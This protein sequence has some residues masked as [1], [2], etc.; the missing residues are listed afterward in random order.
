M[1]TVQ[2]GVTANGFVR[3]P[4]DVIIKSLNN[5]FRASF[6][7]TFDVSPESPDGQVIGI[8]ADEISACWTQAEH[9][10][11]AYRPGATIGIGLD[12]IC[13]L[14]RVVRYKD[15]PSSA[16]V[17]LGGSSG[18]VIP[19]GSIV[20]DDSG[21]E[22]VTTEDASL[23]GQVT[24]N[25]TTLGEIYIAANTITKIIT[26]VD[27]WKTV[28]NP[29]IGQTGIEF[30][31]DPA[32]RVRREKTTAISGIATVESIYARL[33]SLDLEYIRIRDNDTHAPIGSQPPGTLYVVVDGGNPNEIARRIYEGKTGGVPTHGE[34]SVEVKDSK[35]NPHTIKF[36]RTTPQEIY[37]TATFKR[38]AGSNLGSNDAIEDLQKAAANYINSLQ[39]GES[40]VWSYLFRPLTAAVPNIE[41]NSLFI[42][43]QADPKKTDTIILDIDKRAHAEIINMRITDVTDD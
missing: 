6:G 31:A 17:V 39:P 42:D 41:I 32:L 3:K 10:F 24:V 43:I 38:R 25:C 14:S 19:E 33:V 22:F 20:G 35:G 9:G 4:V 7:S 27:G 13:E 11:N 40:V 36:S 18:T 8:V 34:V 5:K 28:N 16:T 30:E 12:N 21:L 15:R 23:P 37:L 1:A 26:P 29:E 2:Y